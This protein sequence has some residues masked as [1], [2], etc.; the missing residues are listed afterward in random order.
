MTDAELLEEERKKKEAAAMEEVQPQ[1]PVTFRDYSV[2][3]SPRASGLS[4][5][6]PSGEVKPGVDVSA[7]APAPETLPAPSEVNTALNQ[8]VEVGSPSVDEIPSM[9]APARGVTRRDVSAPD[10]VVPAGRFGG[11]SDARLSDVGLSP[12]Q[13]RGRIT[14]SSEAT[15]A[16][17][18][19][20]ASQATPSVT[21]TI[22]TPSGDAQGQAGATIPQGEAGSPQAFF[23]NI[24]NQRELTPEEIARGEARAAEMG[25]TFDPNVGFSRKAFEDFQA[26]QAGATA[27]AGGLTTVGGAPL[28]EFLGGQ[29]MPE[30]GFTQPERPMAGRGVTLTP[31]Q[32]DELSAERE[33]RLEARRPGDQSVSDRERRAARGEG[34]SMADR[35]AMAKASARGAS[36]SEIARGNKIADELGVDLRTGQPREAEAED[37]RT[38]EQIESDRLAIEAQELQNERTRQI[39]AKGKEPNAT[40]AEKKAADRAQAVQDGTIT[41]AQ[42][43]DANKRDL[44]GS[45]PVG[46][47]TWA[48]Y[49]VTTGVDQDGDGKVATQEEAEDAA[50]SEAKNE[51]SPTAKTHQELNAAAK[52][53]GKSEYTFEGKKYKVQ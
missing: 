23:A 29:A 37:T 33:A 3:E 46:Y 1:A 50:P 15:Q 35:T 45:P 16:A 2:P 12:V 13:G 6:T 22:E 49:E 10:Q 4:V 39:I 44:L 11:Q 47:D 40:A 30:R 19:A 53:A 48:E 27:P 42:A 21:P 41:Q 52:K 5:F 38:P 7:I 51:K 8:E 32:M 14:P 18:G 17:T 25:T 26:A 9:N 36:P 34:I 31:E 28:A 20:S 43:D 24:R